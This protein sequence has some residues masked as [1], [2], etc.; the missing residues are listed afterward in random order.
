MATSRKAIGTWYIGYGI[1]LIL[2]GIA[3]FISNPTAA[4]TALMS[5]GTFVTLSALWCIW[6]LKAGRRAAFIAA[7]LTTL[8]LAIVFIWRSTVSW[9]AVAQGEPKTFAASLISAMF[10]ASAL[11]LIQLIKAHRTLKE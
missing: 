7:L 11:S 10:L 5:G 8:M 1:F 4:K 2:C 6:M 9:Q 3:G